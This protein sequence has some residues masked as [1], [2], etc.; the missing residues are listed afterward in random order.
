MKVY[1][2][3]FTLILLSTFTSPAHAGCRAWIKNIIKKEVNLFQEASEIKYRQKIKKLEDMANWLRS[4]KENPEPALNILVWRKIERLNDFLFSNSHATNE[5]AW[6]TFFREFE[7]NFIS[8]KRGKEILS[9]LENGENINRNTF[10]SYLK[11]QDYPSPYRDFILKVFDKAESLEL[12]KASFRLEEKGLVTKIATQ[13]HE[14]RM[15]RGH[16]EGL[17]ENDNCNEQCKKMINYLLGSLGSESDKEKIINAAFFKGS[18][19]PDINE[20]RELLYNEELFVL[21][22][23]KR[24][25]NAEVFA[26]LRGI[27]SQ[28]EILDTLLGFIY[29]SK[30]LGKARAVKLFKMVYD[31]AARKNHFPKIQRLLAGPEEP[32]KALDLLQSINSTVANDELLVTFARRVDTLSNKKWSDI[33]KAAKETDPNFQKRMTEASKKADARGDLSVSQERSF[34]G[35]IAALVVIG[36][37]TIGYFYFDGLPTSIEDYLYS[38]GPAANSGEVDVTDQGQDIP[39]ILDDNGNIIEDLPGPETLDS[40]GV[41]S[42]EDST[43]EEVGDV[44]TSAGRTPSS[45]REALFTQFWCGLFDCR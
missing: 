43:L 21:T 2:L 30:L 40:I 42:E 45:R 24:E 39:V 29:K 36:V 34:V 20:M 19:R 6:R 37:P 9:F 3:T 33:F 1:F 31:S 26:F 28:P 38:E 17:M 32:K 22:R 10:E 4:K 23:L 15:V 27:I 5:R 16:I 44:I 12:L 11:K 7:A 14:Y 35:K 18:T 13:Y 41:N 8:Y 25:R